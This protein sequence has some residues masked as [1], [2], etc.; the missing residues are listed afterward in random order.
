[1]KS[2]NSEPKK[3]DAYHCMLLC[4]SSDLTC[5][6]PLNKKVEPKASGGVGMD[7]Y[8]GFQKAMLPSI[9]SIRVCN[10]VV[11]EN[12]LGSGIA[13]A[14]CLS[15]KKCHCLRFN[16]TVTLYYIRFTDMAEDCQQQFDQRCTVCGRQEFPGSEIVG[17]KV[18]CE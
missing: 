10:T 11:L 2:Q 15:T 16:R 7:L 14:R 5:N 18:A 3:I 8:V 17:C 6:I 13:T 12:C 4:W 9:P 1:M